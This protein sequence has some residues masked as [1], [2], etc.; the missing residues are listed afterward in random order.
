MVGVFF[1][2]AGCPS[3]FGKSSLPDDV[4]A[5]PAM[6]W[7]GAGGSEIETAKLPAPDVGVGSISW[8]EDSGMFADGAGASL[9]DIDDALDEKPIGDG[10]APCSETSPDIALELPSPI[11]RRIVMDVIDIERS[12]N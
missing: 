9:W 12:L 6:S 3:G 4:E 10:A 1:A 8:S 5:A 7:D 11:S 2:P